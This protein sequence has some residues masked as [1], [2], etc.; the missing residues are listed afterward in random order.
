MKNA[1]EILKEYWKHDRFRAPQ[2]KIINAVLEN[3]D[4]LALLPT[5]GGK[6]VC[7]QIPALLLE[8]VCIVISPLIALMQDQVTQLKD[9]GIKATTIPSGSSP[10]DIITLFDTI[11]F[12]KYKFL[13]LSPERLQSTLIQQKIKELNVNLIAIDEAHCISEWG[14][15]FRPSYRH[16]KVLREIH[17]T[18]NCI[19]LT[20]SATQKVI[21]DIIINLEFKEF[22]VFKKSF[23]RDNLAYQIFTVEDK[24]YRLQQIFSKTKKTAIVYVNTRKRTEEIANFLIANGH[25]SSFYH[26]GLTTAQKQIAFENWMTE[27]TPIM[28]ATNAFGMG[29]DKPNVGVVV[30]YNLP[31]S[32]ENYLQEAGRAGRDGLKSFS[33]VLQNK[34]DLLLYKEQLENSLPTILEIKEVYTKL[35]QHFQIANGELIEEPFTFNFLEFCKKYNL[36]AHKLTTTLQI[37]TN[38]EILKLSTNFD[39]KSTVQFIVHNRKILNYREKSLKTFINGILRSYGGLFQ[40]ETKIDEYSLAKKLGITSRQVFENL[41]RLEKDGLILYQQTNSESDLTFLVPREDDKTINRFSKE[42]KQYLKQR[43]R[44]TTQL[45]QFIENDT[46]CRSIQLLNYFNEQNAK[47]CGMCDVC[48]TKKRKG[49]LNIP[50]QLLCLLKEKPLSSKEISTYLEVNEKDIL[51]HLRNLLGSNTIALNNYNKFY[52]KNI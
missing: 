49:I 12:G 25:K 30:H 20:A 51:I 5:G 34:N 22:E 48:L 3:K 14:H 26:G 8:G 40:Q 31:N 27:K 24:L 36:S 4:T 17:P 6:S 21:D 43:H 9:K 33:A 52:L 41:K 44:K 16:I 42:I 11:K 18:V 13:Y 46:I 23:Y 28:V 19:A 29:I 50:N 39:K 47:E 45:I 15:D 38:H 1:L 32:V 37:L 2:D 10:D 35:F 7:F